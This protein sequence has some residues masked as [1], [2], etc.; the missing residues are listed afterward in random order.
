MIPMT[1]FIY[2]LAVKILFTLLIICSSSDLSS[3][4]AACINI[5]S[6]RISETSYTASR[7]LNFTLAYIS[8]FISF[9]FLECFWISF[10]ASLPIL[11]LDLFPSDW[12]LYLE[13]PC[14]ERNS[15]KKLFFILTQILAWLWNCFQKGNLLPF[16]THEAYITI[17]QVYKRMTGSYHGPWNRLCPWSCHF[18]K[19]RRWRWHPADLPLRMGIYADIVTSPA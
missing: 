11:I 2:D 12:P 17:C 9:Y 14:C 6:I 18:W 4:C 15:C 5:F 16:A 7:T 19:Q 1:L 10:I 3:L 8:P 13:E